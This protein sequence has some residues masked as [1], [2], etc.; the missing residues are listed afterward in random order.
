MPIFYGK[1]SNIYSV[2]PRK[3]F[4]DYSEFKN[5][6]E[7]FEYIENMKDSEFVDRLNKC[8]NIYMKYYDESRE[9]TWMRKKDSLDKIIE[10]C[11]IITAKV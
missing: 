4:I 8:I 6:D 2:F 9:I 11:K 10:K 1:G 5:P 3:S 7:L